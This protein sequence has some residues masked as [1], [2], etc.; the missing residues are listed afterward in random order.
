MYLLCQQKGREGNEEVVTEQ[1][2]K[3]RIKQID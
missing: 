1:I 2:V 3:H